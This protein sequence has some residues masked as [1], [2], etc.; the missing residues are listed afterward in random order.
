VPGQGSAAT[1]QRVASA[2]MFSVPGIRVSF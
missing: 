2:S 1:G